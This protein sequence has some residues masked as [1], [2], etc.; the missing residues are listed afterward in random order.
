MSNI[1]QFP[2]IAGVDIHTDSEGRFNLNALHRASGTTKT[3]APNEWLRTQQANDLVNELKSQTGDS[4]FDPVKVKRGGNTPGTFADELLAISY[5][6][7]INP[8]FQLK[9]NRVFIDYRT[10]NLQPVIPQSLPD[11][12]RLAADLAEE[13]KSMKPKVE[14]F[15]RIA[16]SDGSMCIRDAAKDLQMR[17]TD[18]TGW[19]SANKWIY[20]RTGKANWIA[21]QERIQS[22]HLEHK[23]HIST[24]EDGTEKITE[25][26]R[27]T[28]KGLAKLASITSKAAA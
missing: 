19:L 3:K 26:V 16:G 10:G 14:A 5:A 21:Y 25:Q 15:E 18:L 20:K 28:P 4:R 22:G 8:A 11:A 27:V 2:V 17:P 24:R 23:V 6:G 13:N 1:C 9:V 12:L 7:W